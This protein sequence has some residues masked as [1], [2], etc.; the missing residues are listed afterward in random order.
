MKLLIG[1]GNPGNRYHMNRH[2]AGILFIEWLTKKK[3]IN[4]SKIT[5]KYVLY[6]VGQYKNLTIDL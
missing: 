2:N 3:K 6:P 5:N 4:P 1:I